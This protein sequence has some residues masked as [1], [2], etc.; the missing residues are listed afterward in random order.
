MNALGGIKPILVDP[1][2]LKELRQIR[3]LEIVVKQTTIDDFKKKYIGKF[4]S[5]MYKYGF[6]IIALIVIGYILYQ[7]YTW[8][9][10]QKNNNNNDIITKNKEQFIDPGNYVCRDND[11]KILQR[12]IPSMV[13]DD[14]NRQIRN[15]YLDNPTERT[16]RNSHYLP[17]VT[18]CKQGTY[19]N[20]G[21]LD[22]IY[23]QPVYV[24]NKE[25]DHYYDEKYE[26]IIERKCK[27]PIGRNA[28]LVPEQNDQQNY[29][30]YVDYNNE[31]YG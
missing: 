26:D 1:N 5:F 12:P 30:E 20:D 11:I 19:E 29:Y 28:P 31:L 24:Y 13:N 7:R 10:K 16:I 17:T 22:N 27:G 23:N 2:I 9:Q 6:I 4:F 3:E 25:N 18:S 15:M 8:Y 14:I 21:R